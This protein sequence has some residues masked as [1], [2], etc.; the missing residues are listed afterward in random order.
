MDAKSHEDKEVK[1][2][3]SKFSMESHDRFGM[4]SHGCMR[5]LDVRTLE[6]KGKCCD[7]QSVPNS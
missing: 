2:S 7:E 1:A 3:R 5:F 4:I 6:N